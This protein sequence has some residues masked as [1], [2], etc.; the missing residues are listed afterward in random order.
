MKYG[1]RGDTLDSHPVPSSRLDKFDVV[2]EMSLDED[3]VAIAWGCISEDGSRF[4]PK[5]DNLFF[6]YS[7]V[8]R[9]NNGGV[10]E[11]SIGFNKY[12][13]SVE[14]IDFPSDNGLH[15]FMYKRNWSGVVFGEVFGFIK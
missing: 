3:V 4:L 1:F 10:V 6:R 14:L 9:D 8:K 12:A 2:F 11:S 5:L 7:G 15:D 13:I